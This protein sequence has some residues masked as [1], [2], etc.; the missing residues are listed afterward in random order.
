MDEATF[1]EK[2]QG[3]G[4]TDAD[5]NRFWRERSEVHEITS[6]TKIGRNP[7]ASSGW[8][9][10]EPPSGAAGN[11]WFNEKTGKIWIKLKGG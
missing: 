8:I 10:I 11:W 6:V 2:L 1:R 5:I 9:E 4:C 3:I 7:A